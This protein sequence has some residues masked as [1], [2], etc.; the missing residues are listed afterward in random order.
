[1]FGVNRNGFYTRVRGNIH[2]IVFIPQPEFMVSNIKAE[3]IKWPQTSNISKH[4]SMEIDFKV[5]GH[6]QY[7]IHN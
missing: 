3:L 2:Y 1:M 6:V 4:G 7:N 5:K